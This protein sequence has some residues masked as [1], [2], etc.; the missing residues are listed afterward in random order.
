L[1]T[2]TRGK[3]RMRGRGDARRGARRAAAAACDW[4]SPGNWGELLACM[5]EQGFH[6]MMDEG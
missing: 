4:P 6:D 2:H 3:W 1:T 5:R